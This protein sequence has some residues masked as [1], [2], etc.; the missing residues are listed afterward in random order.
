MAIVWYPVKFNLCAT[1]QYIQQKCIILILKDYFN[2]IFVFPSSKTIIL[3]YIFALLKTTRDIFNVLILLILE[4]NS[5]L[6]KMES[7]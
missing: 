5:S 7:Y 1:V 6:N 2:Q 3:H 4:T